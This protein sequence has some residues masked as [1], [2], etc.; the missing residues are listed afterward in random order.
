VRAGTTIEETVQTVDLM[1]TLL[2]LSR[3]PVPEGVQGHSLVPL[4]SAAP[5]EGGTLRAAAGSRPAISEK[6]ETTNPGGPPPRDTAS[7][8]VISGG[9]K[10]IHNTKRGAGKPE[11]ELFDH[12]QD[13]LDARDLAAA[14][15]DEVARLTKVLASWRRMADAARL[16]PDAEANKSLSKEELERLRS[17][18][19]IQ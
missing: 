10:L 11:F 18:G 17:L 2:E 4:L 8:A 1:P 14:H 7:V 3:L 19:Y 9:W 6:A 5:S 16:K 15:P 13:P 12:A